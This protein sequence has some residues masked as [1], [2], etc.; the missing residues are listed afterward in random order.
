MQ[1]EGGAQLVHEFAGNHQ[2]Q[3]VAPGG[4]AFPESGAVVQDGNGTG[5]ILRRSAPQDDRSGRSLEGIVQEVPKDGEEHVAVGADR[6]VLGNIDPDNRLSLNAF[7][8]LLGQAQEI[9]FPH[10]RLQHAFLVQRPQ[11]QVLQQRGGILGRLRE[12]FQALLKLRGAQVLA[13]LQELAAEQGVPR[14][15]VPQVVGD[16]GEQ[17]VAHVKLLFQEAVL[18]QADDNPRGG[19]EQAQVQHQEGPVEPERRR[20]AECADG[21]GSVLPSAKKVGALLL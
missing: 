12:L 5:E 16:D 10:Y 4:G 14:N 13:A 3:A 6:Q 11:E 1:V 8:G 19:N 20:D 7:Y 21:G 2:A 17:A 15:G 9:F 18:P